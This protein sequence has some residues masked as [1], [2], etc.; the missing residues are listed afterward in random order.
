MKKTK[1][2]LAAALCSLLLLALILTAPP[3]HAEYRDGTYEVAPGRET[4][5][6]IRLLQSEPE[7][8]L[9]LNDCVLKNKAAGLYNGAY[10]AVKLA[11]R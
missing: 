5:D 7:V 6:M 2:L 11:A 1:H 10:E 9:N 4:V 3:A 8:L